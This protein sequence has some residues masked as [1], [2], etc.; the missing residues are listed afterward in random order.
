VPITEISIDKLQKMGLGDLSVADLN[1]DGL[2][3]MTD[4]ELSRQGQLL[5]RAKAIPHGRKR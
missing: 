1:G 2:L 5:N 3:N 4:V